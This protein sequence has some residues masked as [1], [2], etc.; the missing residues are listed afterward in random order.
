M[1]ALEA[2]EVDL[3]RSQRYQYLSHGG[4][5]QGSQSKHADHSIDRGGC[6]RTSNS[7]KSMAGIVRH[8]IEIAIGAVVTST[9][10]RFK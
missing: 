1:E 4:K 3:I 8:L 10:Q 9:L 7:I 6:K 2:L 5:P